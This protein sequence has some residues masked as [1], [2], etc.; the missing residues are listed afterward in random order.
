MKRIKK[1]VPV[2]FGVNPDNITSMSDIRGV[3][4]MRLVSMRLWNYPASTPPQ[5]LYLL[6]DNNNDIAISQCIYTRG[7]SANVSNKPN[8]A[9]PLTYMLDQF[10]LDAS[11]ALQ[12]NHV[13]FGKQCRDI[14]WEVKNAGS[15]SGFRV[16]LLDQT[17]SPYAFGGSTVC[18]LIFSIEYLPEAGLISNW[19]TDPSV[20]N[21]LN[22]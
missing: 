14:C 22:G 16:S 1:I 8:G 12:C 17:G 5:A 21:S 19:A 9:V 18:Q 2:E 3:A 6:I 4:S 15:V 10:Y 20:Q 7:S 13:L 11:N